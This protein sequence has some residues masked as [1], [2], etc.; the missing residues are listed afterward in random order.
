MADSYA[1]ALKHNNN[2]H[3]DNAEPDAEYFNVKPVFILESDI[4]GS[5]KPDKNNSLTLWEF[6][7]FR[8]HCI[9]KFN[10]RVVA[11]DLKRSLDDFKGHDL[12]N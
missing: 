5:S 10:Q 1:M 2:T 7:P 4:F 12:F 8:T 3:K 9:K 11:G 6:I